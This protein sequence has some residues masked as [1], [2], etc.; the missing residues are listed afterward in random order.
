MREEITQMNGTVR[1]VV[2][3]VGGLA[4]G[5]ASYLLLWI[6]R[7]FDD[8][9]INIVAAGIVGIVFGSF[10]GILIQAALVAQRNRTV[11]LERHVVFLSSFFPGFFF[12]GF[13]LLILE[14]GKSV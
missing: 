3:I 7:L 10:P 1:I 8:M 12:T 5:V 13:V 6:C 11:P 14:A 4:G 2:T 9:Q